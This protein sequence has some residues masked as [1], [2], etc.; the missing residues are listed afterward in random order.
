MWHSIMSARKEA[1]S[2]KGELCKAMVDGPPTLGHNDERQLVD[3]IQ[4]QMSQVN[5]NVTEQS[6]QMRTRIQSWHHLIMVHM[7]C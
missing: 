2:S 1:G 4:T 6:S 7:F 5:E 3:W